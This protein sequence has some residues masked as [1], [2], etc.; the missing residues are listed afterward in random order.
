MRTTIFLDEKE[1]EAIES[2]EGR[3]SMSSI[4]RCLLMAAVTDDEEWKLLLQKEPDLMKAKDSIRK[5][6][7]ETGRRSISL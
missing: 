5:K 7:K 6:L 1:R 4:L 3:V 2:F